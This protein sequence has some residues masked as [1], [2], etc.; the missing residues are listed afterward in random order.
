MT[1]AIPTRTPAVAACG[2]RPA[3]VAVPC[4]QPFCTTTS[5]AQVRAPGQNW[6]HL[7]AACLAEAFYTLGWHTGHGFGHAE[8]RTAWLAAGLCG[9][10]L[11]ALSLAFVWWVS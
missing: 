3:T 5:V 8:G 10:A 7:C 6:R 4:D 2:F 11:G 1:S 9:V